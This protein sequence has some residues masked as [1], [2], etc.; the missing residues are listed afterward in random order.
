MAWTKLSSKIFLFSILLLA[1]LLRMGAA[2][3][4]SDEVEALSYISVQTSYHTLAT[5]FWMGTFYL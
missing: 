1:V 3:A 4:L 2:L 5:A